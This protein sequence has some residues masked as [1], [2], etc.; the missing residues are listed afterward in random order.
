MQYLEPAIPWVLRLGD[1]SMEQAIQ[2]YFE[3]GSS[4]I[5]EK[6]GNRAL[7][8]YTT[9]LKLSKKHFGQNRYFHSCALLG[10]AQSMLL[11]ES[12]LVALRY[13][14]EARALLKSDTEKLWEEALT[15]HVEALQNLD[16][17]EKA[18]TV[19]EELVVFRQKKYGVS[20]QEL[21]R[22]C[23]RT[24]L[25]WVAADNFVR[26][27]EF[28]TK[29]VDIEVK[30]LGPKDPAVIASRKRLD[31]LKF[32]ML[33]PEEKPACS[34]PNCLDETEIQ[35]PHCKAFQVCL[36]HKPHISEHLPLC[37][38]L[39]DDAFSDD[40]DKLR[41][42]KCRRCRKETKLKKCAGC[43]LVR[44]CGAECQNA[45]WKRHKQFCGKKK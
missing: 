37:P 41:K 14:E 40:D 22:S 8:A 18:A 42:V 32:R 21:V 34:L 7:E 26:A 9:G 11:L 38:K 1:E 2:F 29:A 17:C 3:Y 44:Y 45:D 33:K 19:S 27:V 5:V 31:F 36:S 13:V 43:A 25:L 10:I 39:G 24:V 23:H 12:P 16:Q 30:L 35:C 20:S 15:L 28:A 4:H 6:Q